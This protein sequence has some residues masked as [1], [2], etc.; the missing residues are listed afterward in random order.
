MNR[1][2]SCWIAGLEELISKARDSEDFVP[3]SLK[4]FV[5][6]VVGRFGAQSMRF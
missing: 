4:L 5:I 2:I 6:Y 1:L 3:L